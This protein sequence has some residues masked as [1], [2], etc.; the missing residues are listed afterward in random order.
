CRG[1]A[2][3]IKRPAGEQKLALRSRLRD[4][5]DA[6]VAETVAQFPPRALPNPDLGKRWK[7][8]Q[9]NYP[10]LYETVAGIVADYPGTIAAREIF[11]DNQ[12]VDGKYHPLYL[13]GAATQPA[14]VYDWF[15]IQ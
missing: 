9:Q 1:T 2:P 10:L 4:D 3:I 6:A 13:H 14:L 15:L 12:P 8:R 7:D 11:V 5:P